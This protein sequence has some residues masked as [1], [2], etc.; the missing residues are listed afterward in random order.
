MSSYW[1]NFA[2]T[3]D[4]NGKGLARWP[5]YKNK[6]SGRA[7]VLGDTQQPEPIVETA[8]FDL[9]DK[10]YAKQLAATKAPQ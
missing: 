4:P 7:M 9:Y 1:V 5:Q 2:R 3:G 8:K 6:A 10:L